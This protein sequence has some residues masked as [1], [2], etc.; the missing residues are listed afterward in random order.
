MTE[1][2]KA[3]RKVVDGL[4]SNAL[5]AH[6]IDKISRAL[7]R[8]DKEAKEFG[9]SW[10]Q[11]T[12][13]L[14]PSEWSRRTPEQV[15]SMVER[16]M[17]RIY[18]HRPEHRDF[19]RPFLDDIQESYPGLACDAPARAGGVQHHRPHPTQRHGGCGGV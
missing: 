4:Q 3:L 8:T 7:T 2:E 13:E 17:M 11:R 10:S 12:V 15:R 5:R 9:K 1:V 14:P 18:V 19:L 6:Y 16:R